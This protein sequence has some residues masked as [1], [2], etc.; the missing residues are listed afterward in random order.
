MLDMVLSPL[1]MKPGVM[2]SGVVGNDHNA[3]P[4]P[5]T[6]APQH[7]QEGKEGHGVEF[8]RLPRKTKLSISQPHGAKVSYAVSRRMMEQHWVLG[9]RRHPHATP[10]AVLLKMHFIRGP[11]VYLVILH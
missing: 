11:Q 3:A 9:F 5:A 10:G 6:S 2:V 1:F 7:L 4:G 8:T